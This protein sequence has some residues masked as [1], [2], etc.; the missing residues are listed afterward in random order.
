[1][2]TV[3]PSAKGKMRQF[4]VAFRCESRVCVRFNE[5]WALQWPTE[6]GDIRITVSSEYSAVNAAIMLPTHLVLRALIVARSPNDALWIGQKAATQLTYLIALAHNAYIEPPV[7]WFAYET[8]NTSDWRFI[9]QI[10]Y[11]SSPPQIMRFMRS[12]QPQLAERFVANFGRGLEKSE[13]LTISRSV[14]MYVWALENWSLSLAYRAGHYLYM[15]VEPLTK[16][17]LR[18]YAEER[19]TT[20][21][22]LLKPYLVKAKSREVTIPKG[23]TKEERET[24]LAMY[25]QTGAP[26]YRGKASGMLQTETLRRSIFRESPDTYNALRD[27]TNGLEHGHED[28]IQTNELMIPHIDNAASCIRKWILGRCVPDQLLVTELISGEIASPLPVK[29]IELMAKAE[30]RSDNPH[31]TRDATAPF[32]IRPVA[33]PNGAVTLDGQSLLLP[34]VE[35]RDMGFGFG[36]PKPTIVAEATALSEVMEKLM[37]YKPRGP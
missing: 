12:Y 15:A 13:F 32:Q 35:V 14:A 5:F 28:F 29:R 26:G 7:Q 11:E 31:P 2:A 37:G 3:D 8:E 25:A 22:E 19:G 1:M 4:A 34:S 20:E 23:A 21:D 24:I 27:A 6:V 33:G 9:K 16:T 17:A 10:Q 36:I 18:L 30:F